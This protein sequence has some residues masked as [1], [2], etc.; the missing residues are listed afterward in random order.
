MVL[1]LCP[2]CGKEA[3]QSAKYCTQCGQK[4]EPPS[5]DLTFGRSRNCSVRFES[6]YISRRHARAILLN[7]RWFLYDEGS[8]NGTFIGKQKLEPRRWYLVPPNAI[9]QLANVVKLKVTSEGW[10]RVDTGEWIWRFKIEP[11]QP[12]KFPCP[13]CQ[14]QIPESLLL[15][16]CPAC[17]FPLRWLEVP[18]QLTFQVDARRQRSLCLDLE[19]K[20]IGKEPLEVTVESLV[21]ERLKFENNGLTTK[22]TLRAA[23][24][25]IS[26]TLLPNLTLSSKLPCDCPLLVR[27]IFKPLKTQ[28]E[29][30]QWQPSELLEERKVIV[31]LEPIKTGR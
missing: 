2:Y 9:V 16:F 17:G 14:I 29:R 19:V 13:H 20:G 27:S 10:L 12:T 5:V 18:N 6:E 23:G 1:L 15:A 30:P 24:G 11:K 26:L 7:G 31:R 22:V 28:P 21:P 25:K 4:L 3:R 8:K